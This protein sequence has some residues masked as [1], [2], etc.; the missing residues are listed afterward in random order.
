MGGDT[1]LRTEALTNP[2]PCEENLYPSLSLGENVPIA[3]AL[4]VGFG[5]FL[6]IIVTLTETWTH[7]TVEA[8]FCFILLV[9]IN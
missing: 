3:L 1:S 7:R 4:T 8:V 6:K 9:S 5:P 2:V